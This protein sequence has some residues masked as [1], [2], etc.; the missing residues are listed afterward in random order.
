MKPRQ[1]RWRTAALEDVGTLAAY[2]AGKGGTGHELTFIAE[3]EAV[4][5]LL[6]DH[7]ASGSPR[8]AGLFPDL[9]APLRFHPLRRFEKVLVYYLAMP[10]HVEI[11]RV[12]DASRGLEALLEE[13]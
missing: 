7:P 10:R 8:H 9:P 3:L 6:A 11:V 12:W 4:V 2:Y 5:T 13:S 1:L